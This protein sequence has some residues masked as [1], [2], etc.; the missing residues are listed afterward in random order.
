[1]HFKGR[2]DDNDI[3][4]KYLNCDFVKQILFNF[5][6]KCKQ[7]LCYKKQKKFGIL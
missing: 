7:Q 2:N 5:V 3:G 1:M 4:G 6:T